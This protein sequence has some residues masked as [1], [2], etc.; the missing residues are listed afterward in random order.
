M[1]FLRLHCENEDHKIIMVITDYANYN[2]TKFSV[3]NYTNDETT[4]GVEKET[5]DRTS[6]LYN[7]DS[8]GIVAV[9]LFDTVSS[10]KSD[11]AMN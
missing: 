7:G 4:S 9:G 11:V 10:F 8:A 2:E 6:L 5:H 1:L 3:A